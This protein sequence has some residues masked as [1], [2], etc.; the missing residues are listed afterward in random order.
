MLVEQK[1]QLRALELHPVEIGSHGPGL[2]LIEQN[3]S[4]RGAEAELASCLDE[5]AAAHLLLHESIKESLFLVIHFPFLRCVEQKHVSFLRLAR[6]GFP[7]LF[8]GLTS[9]F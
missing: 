8:A 6:S 9:R 2:R 4:C 3:S 1:L 7:V 5:L